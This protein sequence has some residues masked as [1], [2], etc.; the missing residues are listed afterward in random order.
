LPYWLKGYGDLGYVLKDERIYSGFQKMDRCGAGQPGGRRLVWDRARLKTSLEG[1]PDLWPHMVMCNVLQSIFRIHWRSARRAVSHS[2]I[3]NGST[4]KP[5]ENFGAGILAE[6]PL[7]RQHE[8][9]Y[10]VYNRTGESWLLE[11]F[12]KDSR[13]H[14]ALG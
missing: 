7:R 12:E 8:T 14:G 2:D 9:I 4:H 1:K 5:G 11:S 10:W 13:S 3:S 6:N